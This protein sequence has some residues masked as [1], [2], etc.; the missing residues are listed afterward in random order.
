[1]NLTQS[2]GAKSLVKIARFDQQERE[3]A[4]INEEKQIL[5]VSMSLV[6][7]NN[8]EVSIYILICMYVHTLVEE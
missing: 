4:I 1:M 2:L 8:E 3:R 6:G 7:I 5:L